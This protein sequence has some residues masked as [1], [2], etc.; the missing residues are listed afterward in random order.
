MERW[1]YVVYHK[2]ILFVISELLY[3]KINIRQILCFTENL[4]NQPLENYEFSRFGQ[5]LTRIVFFLS[6][7]LAVFKCFK[8]NF[9]FMN[10]Q[11]LFFCLIL[12]VLIWTRFIFIFIITGFL[13]VLRVE[14]SIGFIV[15]HRCRILEFTSY[16][17][18][19]VGLLG[20]PKMRRPHL[21]YSL[22]KWYTTVK[23]NNFCIVTHIHCA[24]FILI[25][26]AATIHNASNIILLL[27]VC[28]CLF[29][30]IYPIPL[31]RSNL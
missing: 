8:K 16:F 1:F 27:C 28:V 19:L 21:L 18:S 2:C 25:W 26:L 9:F 6:H 3:W 24:C 31:P 29:F 22:C 17:F 14:T 7:R 12:L 20:V 4:K 23:C 15:H 11:R 13:C 10:F 5:H 30:R